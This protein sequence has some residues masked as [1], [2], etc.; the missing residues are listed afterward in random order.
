LYFITKLFCT[1]PF[2]FPHP[3]VLVADCVQTPLSRVTHHVLRRRLVPFPIQW[4]GHSISLPFLM[5]FSGPPS[6]LKNCQLQKLKSSLFFYIP[7]LLEA[8]GR[9]K[10]PFFFPPDH[11]RSG[12]FY[13]LLEPSPMMATPN[14]IPFLIL[15]IHQSVD[16]VVFPTFPS[17]FSDGPLNISTEASMSIVSNRKPS[18]SVNQIFTPCE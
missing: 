1:F 2:I 14:P 3:H 13:K 11:M 9:A 7:R 18:L 8:C 17:L 6:P 12:H 16:L 15:S 10:G 5:L 4:F